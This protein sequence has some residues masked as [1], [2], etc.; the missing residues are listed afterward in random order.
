VADGGVWIKVHPD[1]AGGGSGT[2]DPAELLS[3]PVAVANATA[4]ASYTVKLTDG[5]MKKIWFL[6][7]NTSTRDQAIYS[8]NLSQG[9]LPGVMVGSGGHGGGCGSGPA[10]GA[11][12]GGAGGVIGMETLTPVFLESEGT[13]TI[14]VGGTTL[15]N[16]GV[17]HGKWHPFA[18]QNTHLSKQ[19]EDPF[20]AAMG[21]GHGTSVNGA[22]AHQAS[23]G[24]SGGGAGSWSNTEIM[25]VFGGGAPGLP[26]QGHAGGY[27]DSVGG[28]TAAGGGGGYGGSPHD[29][30]DGGA[31]FD[32]ATAL[33]LDDSDG[34]TKSFIDMVTVDGWIAGGGAIWN[35]TATGGGGAGGTQNQIDAIDFTG[36]GGGGRVNVGQ[37]GK[38][39]AGMV[40]LVTEV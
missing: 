30:M 37:G 21:G 34:S 8:V 10:Q 31:G 11:G 16:D 27:G 7:G 38:G 39:G 28:N 15:H 23:S 40:L 25:G 24:G 5:S 13:Y 26:G 22:A 35:H 17:D 32:L 19:G 1:D 20:I 3:D 36:G 2:L 12:A 9:T 18:A 6:P 4:P 33:M 29:Q 14:T